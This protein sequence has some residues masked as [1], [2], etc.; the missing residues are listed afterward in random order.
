MLQLFP[1]VRT[2]RPRV[3]LLALVMLA[4]LALSAVLAG[5]GGIGGDPIVAASVDGHAISLAAY[6]RML[7]IFEI[8]ATQQGQLVSWQTPTERTALSQVQQSTMDFLVTTQLIHE[9]VQRQHVTVNPKDVQAIAKQLASQVQGMEAQ[10]PNN[11][12]YHTLTVGAEQAARQNAARVD[13][14][15]LLSGRP[16]V[17]DAFMLV[18]Y[19]EAEQSALLKDLKVPTA[20]LRVIELATQTQAEQVRNQVVKQH[21]DFG[22]LA[23]QDSLDKQ[24]APS[25]GEIGIARVGQLGQIDPNFDRYI[26][27][28]TADYSAKTSYAIMPY[29]GKYLLIEIS[30]RSTVALSSI[31]D[32]QTQQATYSA[33]LEVVVHDHASIQQYVAVDATPTAAPALGG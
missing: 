21:A 6:Q 29:E 9:Q 27:G 13:P 12:E 30:Q 26:F 7:S 28:A 32:P 20:H 4:G 22:A 5:C 25:G 33:W 3:G 18:S 23:K 14:L 10:N 31:S 15:A 19:N 8:S 11:T 16:S 17:A 1:A 2:P 24:T